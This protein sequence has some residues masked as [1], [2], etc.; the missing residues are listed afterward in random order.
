MNRRPQR[1]PDIPC[2]VNPLLFQL[3][4]PD[5]SSASEEER[6][7]AVWLCLKRCPILAECA[8]RPK[9]R[10]FV[11]AGVIT[12]AA[13]RATGPGGAPV[14]NPTRTDCKMCGAP[15]PKGRRSLCSDEC[16]R[17]GKQRTPVI[18]RG[19]GLSGDELAS[20]AL[21]GVTPWRDLTHEARVSIV[22]T[23]YGLGWTDQRQA[24]RLGVSEHVVRNVRRR[25]LGLLGN[26]GKPQ[27]QVSDVA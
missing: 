27:P 17:L 14:R 8:T 16:R 9:P 15:L 1:A 5:G 25:H 12:N 4:R 18:E 23:L 22:R 19:S 20:S 21:A 7:T 11:Q 3:G 13:G 24:D 2:V 26:H 10:G 6:R